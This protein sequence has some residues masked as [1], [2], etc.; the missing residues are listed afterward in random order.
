MHLVDLALWL[1]DASKLTC[2]SA[3]IRCKGRPLDP[4]GDAVEDFASA[5]L[6][7]ETGVPVRLACSWNL[8][9]GCDAVIGVEVHGTQGG[10]S[11]RNVGG[12]FYDFEAVRH[13]GCHSQTLTSPPDDWGGRAARA[14]LEQLA[15]SPAYDPAC[16]EAVAVSRVLDAIYS[17]AGVI[18]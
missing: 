16:E 6:Q 12:S 3:Q 18:P 10:A 8:P 1:L 15:Q 9:A 2:E 17:K 14:W 13:D 7:T 5:M 11:F 4:A